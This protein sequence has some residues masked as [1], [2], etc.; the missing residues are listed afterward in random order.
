FGAFSWT[1]TR[2][3][4]CG[5]GCGDAGARLLSPA[6]AGA[7]QRAAGNQRGHGPGRPRGL[8]R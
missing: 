3:Q 4:G 2:F 5:N 1:N 6:P 8:R 7:G